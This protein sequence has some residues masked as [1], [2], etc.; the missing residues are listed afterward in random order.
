MLERNWMRS[1]V[2]TALL[3]LAAGCG[4]DNGDGNG[5][6]DACGAD[7]DNTKGSAETG[8]VKGVIKAADKDKATAQGDLYLAVI[9]RSDF[10]PSSACKGGTPPAVANQVIRCVDLTAG[11]FD[12][13]LEGIP[14]STEE[15]LVLP[16]L[17]MN[18]NVDPSDPSTAGPDAC[19]LISVGATVS[20]KQAGE[21]VNAA[22]I[23]VSNEEALLTGIGCAACA[24]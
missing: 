20:V 12:Y 15:Y 13:T 10:D 3:C 17:D 14:P 18:E 24:P 1:L 2:M 4:D 22:E 5:N 21:T 6:G 8:T 11:S 23:A 16:F 9:R 19:D 7:P